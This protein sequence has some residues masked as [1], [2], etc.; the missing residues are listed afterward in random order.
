MYR[1]HNF[2]IG[3]QTNEYYKDVKFITLS[4]CNLHKLVSTYL[5]D[6]QSM[7][8]NHDTYFVDRYC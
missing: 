2:R 6:E 1:V 7:L 8:I 5:L 4:S 3:M